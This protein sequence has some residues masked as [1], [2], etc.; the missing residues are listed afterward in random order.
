M[1]LLLFAIKIGEWLVLDIS[2]AKSQW[3][4]DRTTERDK[5]TRQQPIRNE[6]NLFEQ[7]LCNLW[8]WSACTSWKLAH[9]SALV[10]VGWVHQHFGTLAT[11]IAWR[12]FSPV[13]SA[14]FVYLFFFVA[15]LTRQ[16]RPFA[17]VVPKRNLIKLHCASCVHNAYALHYV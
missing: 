3:P 8:W 15:S 12:A 1:K 16:R 10:V 13:S 17:E 4:T 14:I 11:R 5:N 2:I 9:Q 7:E 6:I